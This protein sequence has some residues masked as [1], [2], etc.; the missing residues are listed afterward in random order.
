MSHLV[1]PPKSP[2]PRADLHAELE[3]AHNYLAECA[4]RTLQSLPEIPVR[5]WGSQM[6]RTY[7]QLTADRPKHVVQDRHEHSLTEIMNQCA[8]LERLID[9]LTWASIRA[10]GLDH[11][12]VTA[13]NP[14]T[15]ST[16]HDLELRDE[17]GNVAL[18]EVSDV[19]ST[20]DGNQKERKDLQSL[21]CINKDGTLNGDWPTGRRFLVVS[22]EFA[23]RL[24]G[25]GRAVC[26]YVRYTE[27]FRGAGAQGGTVVLEVKP[28][29]PP[30]P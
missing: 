1:T 14:T 2:I 24:E 10:S 17:A 12:Y 23:E 27:V 20:S 29:E 28:R 25:L 21:G 9:A 30:R 19:A 11:Y 7:V 15:S 18:F 6:K 16:G 3:L 8:T 22:S 5:S 26:K 4:K 13:C